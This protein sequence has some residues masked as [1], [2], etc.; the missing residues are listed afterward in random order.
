MVYNTP[1]FMPEVV[2]LEADGLTEERSQRRQSY[3]DRIM[4]FI[5]CVTAWPASEYERMDI[6]MDDETIS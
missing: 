6:G 3:R 2:Q 1:E 5:A 4:G